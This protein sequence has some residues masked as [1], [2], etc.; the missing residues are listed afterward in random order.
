MNFLELA[1]SRYTTKEFDSSRQIEENLL[2]ELMQVL[3]LSPSSINSQPWHFTL[4]GKGDTKHALSVHSGHNQRKVE[5]CSHIV[6]FSVW[7]DVASFEKEAASRMPTPAWSYYEQKV[8]PQG[9]AAVRSWMAHQVYLSLGFFLAACAS[10]GVDSTPMEGIDTEA[11]DK[12]LQQK[13]YRTLFA[14]AIG[15]RSTNDTNQPNITP[16][17]RRDLSDILNEK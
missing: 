13:Q 9:E 11:Y 10:M 2:Q 16:K 7:S 8:K 1:Q 4:V 5:A 15:Y 17:V 14:V 6:I 3:R 12:V